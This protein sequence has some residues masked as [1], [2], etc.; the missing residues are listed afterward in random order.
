[1][2]EDHEH[3]S[4]QVALCLR[5]TLREP[6]FGQ[7][8]IQCKPP[9]EAHVQRVFLSMASMA[10]E[11][12]FGLGAQFS[13]VDLRGLRVPVFT[14]EQ[15]REQGCRCVNKGELGNART[16]CQHTKLHEFPNHADAHID[17]HDNART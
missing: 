1:M 4:V 16:D 17:F 8:D 2:Q 6:R 3:L 14:N 13:A 15:V 12:F 5:G 9:S 10:E 7:E 11:H